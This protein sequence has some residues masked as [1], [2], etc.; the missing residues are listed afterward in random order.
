MKRK[1]IIILIIVGSIF[2]TLASILTNIA[3]SQG[4]PLSQLPL[5]VIWLL[6]VAVTVAGIVVTIVLNHLQSDEEWVVALA[7]NRRQQMLRKVQVFWITGILQQSLR[8]ATLIALGL[9]E[10]PGAVVPLWNPILLPQGRPVRRLPSDTHIIEVYDEVGG[11]LLILGEPG[12]GKTTLLLE[13]TRDLLERARLDEQ[14][15]IPVVFNLSSWA[16]HQY[17]S[18]TRWLIEELH[19]K[20]QISRSLAQKWVDMDQILPLL[21][22]LDEVSPQYRGACIDAIAAYRLEH[23]LIPT[24]V[25]CRSAEYRLQRKQL[26][27]QS[28]VELQPLTSDQIDKYL[29]EGGEQLTAIRNTLQGDSALYDVVSTPLMLSILTLAYHGNS[30][31]NLWGMQS[32]T[33]RRQRI[34]KIYVQRM[35]DH[36]GS[37]A[38]YSLQKTIRLLTWLAKKMAQ[39]SQT[40]FFVA[41]IRPEWLFGTPYYQ[42]YLQLME[43][44]QIGLLL[45]LVIGPVVGGVTGNGFDWKVGL[46]TGLLITISIELLIAIA[47]LNL[48]ESRTR[49]ALAL[50][51]E[52]VLCPIIMF[53]VQYIYGWEIGLVIGLS[54]TVL[55]GG[56]TIILGLRSNTMRLSFLFGAVIGSLLGLGLGSSFGVLV[57]YAMFLLIHVGLWPIVLSILGVLITVFLG[58]ITDVLAEGL[59]QGGIWPTAVGAT[60]FCGFLVLVTFFFKNLTLAPVIGYILFSIG[61]VAGYAFVR[62]YSAPIRAEITRL[63]FAKK[64]VLG[65]AILRVLLWLAGYVPWNYTRFLDH[66]VE[67]VLLRKV[68]HSYIF[69]HQLLLDYFAT[70]ED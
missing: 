69:I 55:S 17:S 20:Y 18:L 28:A 56:F 26:P 13:L 34:F 22:G 10:H 46:I 6:I 59:T 62:K 47:A 43:G 32:L 38:H 27:L 14:H 61:L 57:G 16:L 35:L 31:D 24:V 29:L 4:S 54:V 68:G 5:P 52:M 41:R 67:H 1:S 2:G 49:L 33:V 30:T 45:G 53:G 64:G 15:P 37:Q 25:C 21:D 60:I 11:E 12:S 39:H 19:Q 50:I 70:L 8:G 66:A 9:Q 23:G 44:Y 63:L 48:N 65:L 3:T 51:Y 58:I 36:R 40:E 42:S 7:S